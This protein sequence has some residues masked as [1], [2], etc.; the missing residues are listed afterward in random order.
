MLALCFD[1]GISNL[2]SY[3][4]LCVLALT[5]MTLRFDHSIS[6]LHLAMYS[7]ICVGLHVD[8]VF[9]PQHFQPHIWFVVLCALLI[10]FGGPCSRPRTS[11]AASLPRCRKF[12][13]FPMLTSSAWLQLPWKPD[14]VC[15]QCRSQLC[16]SGNCQSSRRPCHHSSCNSGRTRVRLECSV[17]NDKKS[18]GPCGLEAWGIRGV[19]HLFLFL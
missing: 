12:W 6:N 19:S 8:S 11:S 13:C 14:W 7:Y 17:D 2:T 3:S 4:S 9:Q 15:H 16:D 10:L 5:F 1:H 18:P